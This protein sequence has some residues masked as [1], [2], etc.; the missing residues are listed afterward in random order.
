M[1]KTLT[2]TALVV[3]RHI[4]KYSRALSITF[5]HGLDKK[6]IL[7]NWTMKPKKNNSENYNA[8]NNDEKNL[9][10]FQFSSSKST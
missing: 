6:P 3:N 2:K 9:Q 1:N 8:V 7:R 5:I 10:I 4:I